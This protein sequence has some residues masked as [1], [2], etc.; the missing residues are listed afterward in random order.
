ME[1]LWKVK[2]Q[3]WGAG[4]L[5][6]PSPLHWPQS[7]TERNRSSDIPLGLGWG[8]KKKKKDRQKSSGACWSVLVVTGQ[9]SMA[10]LEHSSRGKKRAA[11]QD[12]WLTVPAASEQQPLHVWVR[13]AYLIPDQEAQG[14]YKGAN[15]DLLCKAFDH[16][17]GCAEEG[18]SGRHAHHLPT[19]FN[20]LHRHK[21]LGTSWIIFPVT[22]K[23]E[24]SFSSPADRPCAW[25][26][27]APGPQRTSHLS[28]PKL[29]TTAES[30]TRPA[31]IFN[32][33]TNKKN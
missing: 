31:S 17:N 20:T 22:E 4:R 3:A 26:C 23:V 2:T 8:Q 16:R 25:L 11:W 24:L 1:S 6:F 15:G 33:S 21:S 5:L 9:V 13:T 10:N 32:H 12:K 14:I 28:P 18:V 19:T 29:P 27:P 30:N 7:I